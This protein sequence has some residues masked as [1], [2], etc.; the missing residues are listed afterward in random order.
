MK[1]IKVFVHIKDE[2]GNPMVLGPGDEL[3]TWAESQVTNPACFD[4][5]EPD[6]KLTQEPAKPPVKAVRGRAKVVK[7]ADVA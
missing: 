5:P 1:I 7:P 2:D 4:E 6:A 3:P